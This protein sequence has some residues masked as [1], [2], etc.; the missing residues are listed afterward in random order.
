MP[1]GAEPAADMGSLRLTC[2]SSDA[3]IRVA[4]IGDLDIATVP[5]LEQVLRD[6]QADADVVV[7]DLRGLRFMGCGAVE[8]M[9]ATDDRAR[10]AGG[11]LVVVRGPSEVERVFALVDVDRL[12]HIVDQPPEEAI[13]F[14]PQE[15][16]AL[17]AA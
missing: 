15:P 1:Q 7:L 12:L 4:A 17:D 11:R 3:G 10:R 2:Q 9:L 13:A 5:Q 14:A 8:L 6:A 16:A